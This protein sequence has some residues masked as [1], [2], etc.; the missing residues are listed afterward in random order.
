MVTEPFP[1][2]RSL[3]LVSGSHCAI[4]TDS[5]REQVQ[6]LSNSAGIRSVI[7]WGAPPCRVRVEY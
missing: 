7:D 4:S 1:T 3:K 6:T 5:K 2:Y